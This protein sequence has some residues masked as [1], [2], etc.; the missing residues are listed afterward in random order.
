M[1]RI[2]PRYRGALPIAVALLLLCPAPA[3]AINASSFITGT[4][5]DHGSPAAQSR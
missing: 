4:V 3:Y 1:H 5:T 2:W